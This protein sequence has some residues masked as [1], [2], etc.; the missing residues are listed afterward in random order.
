MC[1]LYAFIDGEWAEFASFD[2]FSTYA[3]QVQ[4]AAEIKKTTASLDSARNAAVVME[5]FALGKK[6]YDAKY[7]KLV[8]RALR[9]FDEVGLSNDI[10]DALEELLDEGAEAFALAKTGDNVEAFPKG[11]FDV[12][13]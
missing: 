6:A 8:K 12:Q 11:S 2:D 1:I 13:I 4:K 10:F 3:T 9:H 5:E 7:G